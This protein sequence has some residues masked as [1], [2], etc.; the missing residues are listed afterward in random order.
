L[1]CFVLFC[2]IWTG[3]SHF[4]ADTLGGVSDLQI[5]PRFSWTSTEPRAVLP[6]QVLDSLPCIAFS[7]FPID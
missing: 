4:L 7:F 1:F 5:H 3:T 2:F 6:A